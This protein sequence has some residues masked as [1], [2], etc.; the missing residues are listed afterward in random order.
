IPLPFDP[1]PL[2]ALAP[3][4]ATEP[5]VL[6]VG[7]LEWRKGPDVL[8]EAAGLLV[9]RGVPVKLVFCG[10]FAGTIE[11]T[12]VERWLKDRARALG[13]NCHFAGHV[14][15]DALVEHYATA[16]VV[17]VPSRFENFPIAALE[18]SA[19]GR[20]V[21]ATSSNG[22]AAYIARWE[23]GTVVAPT[24]PLALAD[25][26]APYLLDAEHAVSVG[27]HGRAGAATL[28]AVQVAQQRERVYRRAIANHRARTITP[29]GT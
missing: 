3:P 4:R 16:R 25:A 6:T 23:S 12:P 27:A 18:G 24:D 20:P 21:V 26:L 8:M 29:S 19:A 10:G 9:Q 17:A 22:L 28:D 7:R 11:G 15:R 13:V 5:I 14:K 2:A 1:G